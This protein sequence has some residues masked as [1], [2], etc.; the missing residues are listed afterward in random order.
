MNTQANTGDVHPTE[1]APTTPT[2]GHASA[3]RLSCSWGD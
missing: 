2:A 1:S 3:R